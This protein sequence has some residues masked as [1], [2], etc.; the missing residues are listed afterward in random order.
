MYVDGYTAGEGTDAG[1]AGAAA[2][3][4][5]GAGKD[6]K[7]VWVSGLSSAGATAGRAPGSDL[8]GDDAM[9]GERAGVGGG[10]E[11]AGYS[12]TGGAMATSG[13][14]IV[15]AIDYGDFARQ[16]AGYSGRAGKDAKGQKKEGKKKKKKGMTEIAYRPVIQRTPISPCSNDLE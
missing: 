13:A 8:Y 3:A 14:A 4:G 11:S 5:A 15:G 1:F 9:T 6:G 12:G 16:P 10:A 7:V 2:A